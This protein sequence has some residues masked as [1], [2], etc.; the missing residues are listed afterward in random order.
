M[1]SC[2]VTDQPTVDRHEVVSM[3]QEEA[4][5]SLLVAGFLLRDAA[6]RSEDPERMERAAALVELATLVLR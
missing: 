5:R 3:E 1:P 2:A 4:I 6:E